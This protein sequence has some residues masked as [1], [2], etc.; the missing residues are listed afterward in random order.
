[1][2][3]DLFFCAADSEMKVGRMVGIAKHSFG[4]SIENKKNIAPTD[5]SSVRQRGMFI[6]SWTFSGKATVCRCA[7]LNVVIR[8]VSS[9]CQK[10]LGNT[11]ITFHPEQTKML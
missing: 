7:F 6:V 9:P 4:H 8:F 10:F 11:N 1:L 5:F 3:A 2:L